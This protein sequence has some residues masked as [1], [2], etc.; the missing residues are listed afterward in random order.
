MNRSIATRPVGAALS[1]FAATV[2]DSAQTMGVELGAL[3]KMTDPGS[4]AHDLARHCLLI[5][6]TMAAEAESI[7]AVC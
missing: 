2:H 5:A 6:N 1:G 3:I 4:P 7:E